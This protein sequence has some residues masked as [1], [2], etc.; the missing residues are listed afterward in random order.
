M[1]EKIVEIVLQDRAPQ[2][3]AQRLNLRVMGES[4][5]W[6]DIILNESDDSPSLKDIEEIMDQ[7][8]DETLWGVLDYRVPYLLRQKNR[9]LFDKLDKGTISADE[10]R[11][12]DIYSELHGRFVLVRS[13]ALANLKQRGYNIDRYLEEQFL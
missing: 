6:E 4:L 9:D 12:L 3:L 2:N 10:E 1:S 8:C 7:F 13:H 5:V 11:E